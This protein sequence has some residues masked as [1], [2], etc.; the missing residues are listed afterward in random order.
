[1]S[2]TARY[3][4]IFRIDLNYIVPRKHDNYLH[5]V[6]NIVLVFFLMNVCFFK[7]LSFDELYFCYERVSKSP[8]FLYS[9]KNKDDILD[10]MQVIIMVRW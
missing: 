1:M 5:T 6:L 4:I 3:V 9:L 10:S 8:H 7:K 2:Y